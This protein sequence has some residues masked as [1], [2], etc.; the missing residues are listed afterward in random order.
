MTALEIT[1]IIVV[2]TIIFAVIWVKGSAVNLSSVRAKTVVTH[3]RLVA[4]MVETQKR[5]LGGYPLNIDAMLERAAYLTFQGNHA[6]AEREEQLRNA[7]NGPY[8]KGVLIRRR[9][10]RLATSKIH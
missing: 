8:L 5:Q 1:M 6:R 4:D 2:V 9:S 10:Y 3:M 7:W